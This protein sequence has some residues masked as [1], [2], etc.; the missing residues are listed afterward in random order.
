MLAIPLLLALVVADPPVHNGRTGNIAVRPPRSAAEIVVD[1]QLD[2]PVWKQAAILTGFSQFSPQ[3]GIA[4]SD[5]TQVLVWYSATAIHF[6]V[7]AFEPHGTVRATLA[8]RDRIATDDQIQ[9]LIGTFNDGRQAAMFAVNPFGIQADGALVEQGNRGGGG[10]TS[11]GSSARESADLSQDYVF[12][13]KGRLTD[14]GYEIEVTIPFKSLRF[15]SVAD[16]TWGFNVVRRVQHSNYE[17]SWTPALRGNASFLSQSGTLAGLT[18]LHRGLVLDITPELTD[19][20]DGAP[21]TPRWDYSAGKPQLGGT[22]RWGI[23]N[24][25]TF[26]GT[27]N[28]DFSQ[29]EADAG[30]VNFDPRR[31]IFIPERRPF[32]IDGIEQFQTP[33]GLVYTRRILQPQA[34]VKVAG[35]MG[36]TN[37]ALMS[38]SDDRIASTSGQDNPLFNILRLSRDL[39]AQS[40]LGLTYTDRVDGDNSNRVLSLDGRGVINRIYSGAFQ[41]AGSRTLRNGVL[42]TAPLFEARAARDG[43]ALSVRA[44]INGIDP[45][46]VTQAGFISRT[47]EVHAQISPRYTFFFP[48]GSRIE[49]FAGNMNV[50]GTWNYTNFMRRGDARDKK[51]HF[52][53][54]AQLR[55]GWSVGGSLLL[56]SFGYDPTF[57]ASRFRI[58]APNGVGGLDTLPFVGTARLPNRDWLVRFSSPRYKYLQFSGFFIDGID[59]NFYEWASSD[60]LYAQF[61]LNARPSER[62]R[63]DATYQIQQFNRRTDGSLVGLVRN[64]RLKLEYQVSQPFFVRLIGEYIADQVDALRDDSRTNLPLLQRDASGVYVG[65][66]ARTSNSVRGD[67]LL[68]YTPQPGTVVYLGYGARM[69]EPESFRFERV[70]RS[71]DALFLKLSYLFR[72]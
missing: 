50:D 33:N 69:L 61:T 67:V 41:L 5:S 57:Y 29:V 28:P 72:N 10:L 58:E 20:V 48:R 8:E 38:A 15:Q 37:V 23:T 36:S 19:R 55:G 60:V 52:G 26:N 25:L 71:S 65:T 30:Q 68:A 31:A 9:F 14:W 12:K 44:L 59:E 45:D 3:D 27:F 42:T 11:S 62:I 47:G 17:D 46:F 63:L 54:D 53:A 24:N 70:T 16:Q 22:V 2:E 13:S 32:F 40:R 1:G 7:R 18:D 49:S 4:A 56:E 51:L 35:K 66:V 21:G 43:R 6:G 64:P 39:G 34:A